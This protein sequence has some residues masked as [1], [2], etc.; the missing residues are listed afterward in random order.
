MKKTLRQPLEAVAPSAVSTRGGP[1]S[2]CFLGLRTQQAHSLWRRAPLRSTDALLD[3]D[4]SRS[5]FCPQRPCLMLA[6]VFLLDA[7]L[8]SR[9]GLAMCVSF[10]LFRSRS[11]RKVFRESSGGGRRSSR[12]CK[13]AAKAIYSDPCTIARPFLPRFPLVLAKFMFAIGRGCWHTCLAPSSK[14]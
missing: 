13:M 4:S 9:E 12:L 5:Q 8:C 7:C 3:L 10:A 1:P 2:N 14:S 6:S 11:C